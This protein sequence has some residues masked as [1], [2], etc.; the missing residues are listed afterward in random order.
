[1]N[2]QIKEK[3]NYLH[4]V[5]LGDLKM[6]KAHLREHPLKI[7]REKVDKIDVFEWTEGATATRTRLSESLTRKQLNAI[8][9]TGIQKILNNHVIAFNCFPVYQKA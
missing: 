7:E 1:M 2:K 5:F 6:I 9:D 4:D 8:T 3:V